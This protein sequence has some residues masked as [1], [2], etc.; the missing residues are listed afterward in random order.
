M[1]DFL[2]IG[3]Q[4]G[5]TTAAARNLALHPQITVFRGTTEYGQKELEFF[6]QH[7]ER[8]LAWYAS[9]FEASKG[10]AGEKTAE[11]LHRTVCHQRMHL[12][13]P[14]LKL[15]VLLRSPVERAYSQWKMA[16]LMKGDERDSFE[17]VV[18]RELAI[19]DDANYRQHFYDCGESAVS[20]WRE[21][22]VL[23][24]V[25]ADQLESVYHWFSPRNVF[26]GISEQIRAD[27]ASGYRELFHFLGVE[28]LAG[29]FAD[30]FVSPPCP[31]MPA[32]VRAVLSEV[33][34]E[35]N[36]RLCSMLSRDIPEWR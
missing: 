34:Q 18:F 26:V 8:G 9:H 13:N 7:W 3:A 28:S 24:G 12:C 31:P 14:D 36:R 30:H 27:L 33:Y 1:P 16:S 5:G 23:K 11:L 25:Y 29:P 4:K 2:I 35:P 19:L 22:Y 15:V 6:N 17:T 21:G 20:C 32:R 10:L